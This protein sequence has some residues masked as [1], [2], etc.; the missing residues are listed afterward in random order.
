MVMESDTTICSDSINRAR[1]ITQSVDFY[2]AG[3]ED[4]T[5]ALE[6]NRVENVLTKQAE[7]AKKCDAGD[8]YSCGV[9]EALRQYHKLLH[10]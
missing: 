8:E 3:L 6:R 9:A 10:R 5:R 4:A 7:R 2:L 1:Y